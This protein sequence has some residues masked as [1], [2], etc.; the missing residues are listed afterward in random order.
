MNGKSLNI[1]SSLPSGGLAVN[2]SVRPTN[3]DTSS[4][5]SVPRLNGPV[6]TPLVPIAS[7]DSG[8]PREPT[9]QAIQK[10]FA[11]P[12]RWRG[13]GA[14]TRT[15]K[16]AKSLVHQVPML[17]DGNLSIRRKIDPVF[18]TPKSS[19]EFWFMRMFPSAL[20]ACLAL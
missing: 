20:K 8:H 17:G 10:L 1:S 18:E 7:G 9:Q 5:S 6:S 15:W 12:P 13:A 3:G 14:K 16:S 11:R 2:P 4:C 19:I